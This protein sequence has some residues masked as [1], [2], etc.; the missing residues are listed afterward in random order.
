MPNILEFSTISFAHNTL[1]C[2]FCYSSESS[3]LNNYKTTNYSINN[4]NK[5]SCKKSQK[6]SLEGEKFLVCLSSNLLSVFTERDKKDNNKKKFIDDFIISLAFYLN[7]SVDQIVIAFRLKEIDRQKLGDLDLCIVNLMDYINGVTNG[8]TKSVSY[9]KILNL[10]VDIKFIEEKFENSNY[11]YIRTLD[12]SSVISN[13]LL[14][15]QVFLDV[16]PLSDKKFNVA[17]AS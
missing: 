3:E 9:L 7:I 10:S 12:I 16:L 4:T 8:L 17:R 2:L 6:K 5:N 11:A 15:K 13:P 1:A 14:K